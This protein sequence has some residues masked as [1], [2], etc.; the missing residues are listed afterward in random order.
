MILKQDIFKHTHQK[1]HIKFNLR[2]IYAALCYKLFQP[3]MSY[4]AYTAKILNH[5]D[6]QSAESYDQ[7]NPV[8][9][10]EKKST[11]KNNRL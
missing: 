2:S 8:W 9:F 3:N 4:R 1:E 10:N 5:S 6:L 11:F 7:Y